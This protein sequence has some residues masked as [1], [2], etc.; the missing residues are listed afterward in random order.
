MFQHLTFL[1]H[2]FTSQ[3][4]EKWEDKIICHVGRH[5]CKGKRA[6]Y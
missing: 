1:L 6:G 4:N 5:K 3:K 2:S